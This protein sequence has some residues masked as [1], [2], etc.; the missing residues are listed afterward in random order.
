MRIQRKIIMIKYWLKI[1]SSENNSLI[2]KM[3]NVMKED[4]NNNISY[5]GNHWA[6][7]IKTILNEIGFSFLWLQQK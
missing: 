7:Q 3:Y 5:N 1:L 4:D 6:Y 2:R